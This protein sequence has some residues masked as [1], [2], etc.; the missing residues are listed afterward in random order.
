ML[1]GCFFLMVILLE[2]H[3]GRYRDDDHRE[4]AHHFTYRAYVLLFVIWVRWPEKNLLLF[5]E[6]ESSISKLWNLRDVKNADSD[7][8]FDV[9]LVINSRISS[10]YKMLRKL[11]KFSK[12]LFLMFFER[13]SI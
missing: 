7:R 10:F 1:V 2:F 3:M 5:V 11:Y 4:D 9:L 8:M 12:R 6:S 13:Y